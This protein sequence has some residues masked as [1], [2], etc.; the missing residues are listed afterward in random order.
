MVI[1]VLLCL[2]RRRRAKSGLA[3]SVAYNA[4][5]CKINTTINAACHAVS[6]QI[7]TATNTA[8]SVPSPSEE[9]DVDI[10]ISSNEAYK[11]TSTDSATSVNG[12]YGSIKNN[13]L[14]YDYVTVRIPA[15]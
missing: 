2:I 13:V 6:D 7:M 9:N 5:G 4:D 10:A 12:E 11:A 1:L 3:V 15:I 8:S 14:K